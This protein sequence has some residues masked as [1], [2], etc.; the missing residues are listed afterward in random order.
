MRHGPPDAAKINRVNQEPGDEGMQP[1]DRSLRPAGAREDREGEENQSGEYIAID[2]KGE[3]I[4]IIR[5]IARD[6]PT[7]RPEK[8]EGEGCGA[9]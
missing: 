5:R 9:L 8:D 3:G 7:S 4:G 1:F 6:N 2:E